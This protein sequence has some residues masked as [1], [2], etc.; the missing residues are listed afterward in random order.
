MDEFQFLP[1]EEME[2]LIVALH[3]ISQEGLPVMVV[4]AGLPSLVGKVGDIRS[5]AERLFVF[6]RINSLDRAEA[7]AALERPAEGCGVRWEPD[8]LDAVVSQTR[9]YPHFLQVFGQHC[10]RAAPGRAEIRAADVEV[11]TPSATRYLDNGF[12]QVRFDRATPAGRRYLQ[13]MA[14][15]GPGP[16][17]SVQV[18]ARLGR[19]TSQISSQR[20]A[21]I[22]L[23]LCYAPRHGE[24]GFTVPLFDRFVL[25]VMGS[26]SD[27]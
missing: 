3:R 21:L 2:A 15:L 9:G 11:A 4:G 6:Q 14:V 23:G 17:P 8:A 10:W 16:H 7:R 25:R 18:A 5:Y 12:F 20:D 1:R 24:I 26:P 22:R 13:A 19:R 27:A